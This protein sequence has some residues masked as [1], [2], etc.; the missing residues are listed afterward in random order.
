[1]K[2]R[3]LTVVLSDT[4]DLQLGVYHVE[5]RPRNDDDATRRAAM[6]DALKTRFA[7]NRKDAVDILDGAVA[8]GVV[9]AGHVYSL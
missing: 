8:D 5:V 2:K 7:C 6:L 3:K 1:M 4:E 9:F